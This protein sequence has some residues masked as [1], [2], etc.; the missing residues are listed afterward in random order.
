MWRCFFD[1][2]SVCISVVI[3][4][5]TCRWSQ[6]QSLSLFTV[7]KLSHAVI[8]DTLSKSC[9][10]VEGKRKRPVQLSSSFKTACLYFYLQFCSN[11]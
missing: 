4:C 1:T 5:E 6:R 2:L 10:H 9:Y 3:G 8:H 11:P 7:I